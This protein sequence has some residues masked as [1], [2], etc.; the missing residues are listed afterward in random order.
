MHS[1]DIHPLSEND[2]AQIVPIYLLFNFYGYGEGT[3]RI[4]EKKN[5]EMSQTPLRFGKDFTCTCSHCGHFFTF[6]KQLNSWCHTMLCPNLILLHVISICICATQL[7]D[8]RGTLRTKAMFTEM[9]AC[10]KELYFSF[11]N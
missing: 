1:C 10:K 5:G 6:L 9:Q 7:L 11:E 8:P 3:F 4:L 2:D